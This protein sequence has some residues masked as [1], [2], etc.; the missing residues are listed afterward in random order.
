MQ[1][2]SFPLAA[3][4]EIIQLELVSTLCR[5]HVITFISCERSIGNYYFITEITL[6]TLYRSGYL[7][8]VKYC[9]TSR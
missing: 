2:G 8:K 1:T 4:V 5:L 6:R 7:E 9:N 3:E